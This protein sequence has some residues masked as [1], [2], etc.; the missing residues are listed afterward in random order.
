MTS[1]QQAGNS[2]EA[3]Q[4]FDKVQ[5][6]TVWHHEDNAKYNF[7]QM[8][9]DVRKKFPSAYIDK[10]FSA[11]LQQVISLITEATQ[12]RPKGLGSDLL[13]AYPT[14]AVTSTTAVPS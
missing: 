12:L 4:L 7:L 10:E 2:D 9:S 13:A 6:I 14:P 11:E 5:T 1:L 8:I 3:A